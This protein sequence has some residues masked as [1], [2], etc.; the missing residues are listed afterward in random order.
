MTLEDIDTMYGTG[1]KPWKSPKYVKEIRAM[2]KR[3][4]QEGISSKGIP[5]AVSSSEGVAPEA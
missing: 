3:E 5:P 1:V 4:L 2:R